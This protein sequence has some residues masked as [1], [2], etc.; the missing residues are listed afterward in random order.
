MMCVNI[1]KLTKCE[2][3]IT[4]QQALVTLGKRSA[5]NKSNQTI[6]RKGFFEW[7]VN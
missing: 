1:K 7:E 4:Q 5:R 6:N 2:Y 3:S